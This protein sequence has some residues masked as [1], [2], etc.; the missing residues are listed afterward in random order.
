MINSIG[1]PNKGLEGYPRA[2]PAAARAALPARLR[3]A[4]D[5]ERD[6]LDRRG[7][8]R[9]GRGLR[10]AR[11]GRGDRAQRVLPERRDRPGHRRRPGELAA[12]RRRSAPARAKPLIVKLTPNT[13]D[14]AAVARGGRGGGR[15]R[16]LAD[17]HAARDGARARRRAAWLGGG[18]GGLS[19]PA[20]RAVALAQVAAVAARVSVPVVGH[21]RRADRA[22]RARPARRG[23][24]A[25]R[26]GHRELPRSGRGRAD[27]R[28]CSD[29]NTRL[30]AGP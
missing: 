6:G 14:V 26:R 28:S 30:F 19:G 22:S 12:A 25:G 1:L 3:G 7:A 16:G 23:R 9:A 21:G 4:A 13:A 27:R 10:R 11:R 29:S 24:D 20:V 2:R 15:R 5:H 17:Q 8:R 18:T